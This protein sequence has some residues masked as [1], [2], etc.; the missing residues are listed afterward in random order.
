ME[1]RYLPKSVQL[2]R[3]QR[4]I[5]KH[6]ALNGKEKEA[7][8]FSVP[9]SGNSFANSFVHAGGVLVH[10]SPLVLLRGSLVCAYPCCSLDACWFCCGAFG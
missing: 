4:M 1:A 6:Q 2:A 10:L 8:S 3:T 7:G 5:E 9:G